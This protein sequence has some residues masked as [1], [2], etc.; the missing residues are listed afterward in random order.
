MTEAPP[1]APM[2]WA[3]LLERLLELDRALDK[4]EAKTNV[5]HPSKN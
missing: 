2:S 3:E 4:L 1:P 5:E